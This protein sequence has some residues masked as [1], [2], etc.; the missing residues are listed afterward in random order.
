MS[1]RWARWMD[2]ASEREEGTPLAVVRACTGV[3][4]AWTCFSSWFW[5]A[6][7]VYTMISA[8]GMAPDGLGRIWFRAIG[9]A[10]EGN[11]TAL[12]FAGMAL[13]AALVV[14]FGGRV[15][16][17][18]LGQ[19]MLALF[20]LHPGTG[21]GHD[22]VITN[23]LWMLV[24]GDG[25]RTWSLDCRLRTGSW[26]DRTPILAF[27]RRLLVWQLAVMYTLT[28]LQKQGAPWGAA[29][30]WEAVYRTLLLP[31]WVRWD[32]RGVLAPFYPLLQLST[33]ICWWWETLWFLVPLQAWLL[34]PSWAGTRAARLAGRVDLR[35]W[36]IL[37][38]VITHG[39]LLALCDLGPFSLITMTLYAA[40]Y[41]GEEWRRL[42][43]RL[44]G[45]R[46]P[47][48]P[49]SADTLGRTGSVV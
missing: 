23:I 6:V 35:P 36:F 10:T 32:L 34:R 12:L 39:V 27:P 30:S 38:G 1:G 49:P 44:R 47:A 14:G 48:A 17:F 22:R 21:G 4:V 29:A 25:A 24:I 19:V 3:V 46:A 13:A 43:D 37:L 5:G 40:L 9:G 33:F 16:A 8:G 15:T 7:P 26:E 28:G 20:A 2:L 42:I 45:V 11:V 31:S 41:T 18:L